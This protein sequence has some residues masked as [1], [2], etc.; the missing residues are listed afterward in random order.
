MGSYI[1]TGKHFTYFFPNLFFFSP[2]CTGPFRSTLNG[3]WRWIP[4]LVLCLRR[5]VF[6][7]CQ[8]AWCLLWARDLHQVRA[9]IVWD[10]IHHLLRGLG[11]VCLLFYSGGILLFR[12]ETNITLLGRI[13]PG[14]GMLSF[15]H[16]L[17]TRPSLVQA[18]A[19]VVTSCICLWFYGDVF[20]RFSFAILIKHQQGG[21]PSVFSG[22]LWS[23]DYC[24][25]C[26]VWY[27]SPMKLSG[28]ELFFMVIF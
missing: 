28:P 3:K 14:D 13:S 27:N 12:C 24:A 2:D 1:Y 21:A 6:H 16:V 9:C 17:S 25:P 11:N 18:F 4:Y 23:T 10:E 20:L 5:M 22:S 19:Y 8:W 15:I 26:N 7:L